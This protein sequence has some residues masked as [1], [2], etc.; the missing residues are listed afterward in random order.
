MQDWSAAGMNIMRMQ[1]NKD[2]LVDPSGNYNVPVPLTSNIQGDASEMNFNTSDVQALGQTAQY[3]SQH[4]S[5]FKLIADS[6]SPPN[7]MKGP[8]L[9]PTTGQPTTSQWVGNPS[10]DSP[11]FATPWLSNQYNAWYTNPAGTTT[12]NNGP[13]NTHFAGYSGDSIGGRLMTENPTV[14]AGFG[15]YLAGWV[16]GFQQNYNVPISN[17]SIQNESAFQNPFD[18]MVLDV[19]QHGNTDFNQYAMALQ[20][21]ATAFQQGG[22]TTQI[23]G[24]HMNGVGDS[25]SD[26]WRTWIQVGMINAVKNYAANPNLINSLGI[27]SSNYYVGYDDTAARMLAEYWNGSN[28]V[29]AGSGQTWAGWDDNP[30]GL[31]GDGKQNWYV[32]TGDGGP[33]WLSN[34]DGSAPAIT[35]AL[36]IHNA[37]VYSNAS[38]YLYWQF[39]DGAAADEYSLLGTSQLSDP[40]SSKKLDAFMQ[41]SM[42]IHPGAV[43][44]A[45]TFNSTGTT[46]AG[47]A[48]AYDAL[49]AVDVSAYRNADGSMALVF[50]N[51]LGTSQTITL[52]L[53]ANMN[54]ESFEAWRTSSTEDF[55]H[56]DDLTIS[57]DQLSFLLPAD[58]VES[59]LSVPEPG[60]L[61]SAAIATGIV[62][63]RRNRRRG[64]R[65]EITCEDSRG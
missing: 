63:C 56:L 44:I 3:L 18:S 53:P 1:M 61:I 28:N 25:Q 29:P 59:L 55:A 7:W 46:E 15:Q 8:V 23:R 43:R 51:M 17:I 38:A 20:S 47:G 31:A 26:P 49:D 13:T 34:P 54:G 10:S 57:N 60:G 9:D 64:R 14:L 33:G 11:A 2:V 42:V 27:Y 35:V 40:T 37:L 12:G 58:S 41:Y 6:W 22:L 45:A 16:K 24:P 65:G 52:A 32:E 39:T 50:L 36:K 5:N 62:L 19:D 21:V 48:D 4:T 30:N